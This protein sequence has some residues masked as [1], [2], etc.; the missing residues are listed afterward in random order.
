MVASRP[1]PTPRSRLTPEWPAHPVALQGP[2]LLRSASRRVYEDACP[3]A[4]SA[5]ASA[6][7]LC[8]PA[9]TLPNSTASV[10]NALAALDAA[11]R[12]APHPLSTRAN[13]A[14]LAH[15]AGTAPAIHTACALAA[16]GAPPTAIVTVSGLPRAGGADTAPLCDAL[17]LVPHL[18]V[19][20][21]SVRRSRGRAPPSLTRSPRASRAGP[22]PRGAAPPALARR[23][24]APRTRPFPLSATRWTQWR[25]REGAAVPSRPPFSPIFRGPAR[26]VC[27]ARPVPSRPAAWVTWSTQ[28][29]WPHLPRAAPPSP[30]TPAA[31]RRRWGSQLPPTAPPPSLRLMGRGASPSRAVPPPQRSA[32]RLMPV[33]TGCGPQ[34][35]PLAVA[36]PLTRSLLA[37]QPL[38]HERG[39]AH[40]DCST[41]APASFP[42]FAAAVAF[43]ARHA[44]PLERPSAPPPPPHALHACAA[45]SR[46][47]PEVP[48]TIPIFLV[49]VPLASVAALTVMCCVV[50]R[51]DRSARHPAASAYASLASACGCGDTAGKR[52]V[53]RARRNSAV[54]LPD[55]SERVTSRWLKRLASR[56]AGATAPA[57]APAPSHGPEQVAPTPGYPLSPLPPTTAPAV[58][59]PQPAPQSAATAHTVA[60]QALARH[61]EGADRASPV[62]IGES[63]SAHAASMDEPSS[64]RAAQTAGRASPAVT[65][66]GRQSPSGHSG[67]SNLSEDTRT[68]RDSTAQS[69]VSERLVDEEGYADLTSSVLLTRDEAMRGLRFVHPAAAAAAMGSTAPGTASG[70]ARVNEA[71]DGG[72]TTGGTS[73]D[74]AEDAVGLDDRWDSDDSGSSTSEEDERLGAGEEDEYDRISKGPTF[75]ESVPAPPGA[76][77]TTQVQAFSVREDAQS[78]AQSR[79]AGD[80]TSPSLSAAGV[81]STTSHPTSG[82]S[83]HSIRRRRRCAHSV[84][85]CGRRLLARLSCRRPEHGPPQ[86]EANGAEAA[87]PPAAATTAGAVPGTGFA[88][89]SGARSRRV[90]R[91]DAETGHGGSERE[92]SSVSFWGG[93][94]DAES[95]AGARPEARNRSQG[96]PERGLLPPPAV[97]L[98]QMRQWNGGGGSELVS[99]PSPA[100]GFAVRSSRSFRRV[101]SGDQAAA[102]A[103]AQ[104]GAPLSRAGSFLSGSV[105]SASSR[106]VRDMVDSLRVGAAARGG[107]PA[108]EDGAAGAGSRAAGRAPMF[109]GSERTPSD[110]ASRRTGFQSR[111]SAPTT[112]THTTHTT[113]TG[114]TNSSGSGS[115]P[116]HSSRI[117]RTPSG[118]GTTG[119]SQRSDML[120]DTAVRGSPL[121]ARAGAGAGEGGG[122]RWGSAHRQDWVDEDHEAAQEGRDQRQSSR[123]SRRRRHRGRGR[124]RR[125]PA[126]P[127]SRSPPSASPSPSGQGARRRPERLDLHNRTAAARA[128]ARHTPALVTAAA[129]AA[130]GSSQDWTSSSPVVRTRAKRREAGSA[131]PSPTSTHGSPFN[132]SPYASSVHLRRSLEQSTEEALDSEVVVDSPLLS[133]ATDTDADT[134]SQGEAAARPAPSALPIAGQAA[135]AGAAAESTIVEGDA[136]RAH[137]LSS[138]LQAGPSGTDQHSAHAASPPT[139][140]WPALLS[141]GGCEASPLRSGLEATAG[142]LGGEAAPPPRRAGASTGPRA[143]SGS[144]ASGR[145]WQSPGVAFRRTDGSSSNG[146]PVQASLASLFAEQAGSD[147][148]DTLSVI[149]PTRSAGSESNSCVT[150]G[151]GA[152]EMPS[153]PSPSPSSTQDGEHYQQRMPAE[154][155]M[156][157]A[158]P[159][160]ASRLHSDLRVTP[161]RGRVFRTSLLDSPAALSVA[162]TEDERSGGEESSPYLR[163]KTSDHTL[164]TQAPSGTWPSSQASGEGDTVTIQLPVQGG[165]RLGLEEAAARG[166]SAALVSYT[167]T[168]SPSP[169]SEATGAGTGTGTGTGT[170]G[171]SQRSRSQ[172]DR[173]H[174]TSDGGA[175]GPDGGGHRNESAPAAQTQGAGPSYTLQ[176]L[177]APSPQTAKTP[178]APT[179]GQAIPAAGAPIGGG[180]SGECS[181][182][183]AA[184]RPRLSRAPSL[185][186]RA[187]RLAGSL[188][189]M[190]SSMLRAEGGKGTH[191]AE[192]GADASTTQASVASA[193]PDAAVMQAARGLARRQ[194]QRW[195]RDQQRRERR[196]RGQLRRRASARA[197]MH[198]VADGTGHGEDE[199]EEDVHDDGGAYVVDWAG[200]AAVPVESLLSTTASIYGE[201]PDAPA[202]SATPP[203]D[204]HASH[205]LRSGQASLQ[206]ESLLMLASA[207]S[208]ADLLALDEQRERGRSIL[209]QQPRP[210]APEGEASCGLT[211]PPSGAAP[212][213]AGAGPATPTASAGPLQLP[214]PPSRRETAAGNERSPP[215]S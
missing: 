151:A 99:R 124:G 103:A 77:S 148:S 119:T 94:G 26:A 164:P 122:D 20:G 31:P 22:I 17:R 35:S 109:A 116:A 130:E 192:A 139:G 18:H 142:A 193:E 169:L 14:L 143:R 107:G 7:G 62:S 160:S 27:G 52:P 45:A 89:G 21:G 210:A 12:A 57:P 92:L 60:R 72:A 28:R 206:P 40:R 136:R 75:G 140:G 23:R 67:S 76:T 53:P 135:G 125:S 86:Y 117:S 110:T 41:A 146:R 112:T 36:P 155:V 199:E 197:A 100:D 128:R 161:Q 162:A 91:A 183:A 56:G 95:E 88:S 71:G 141:G 205:L 149:Q 211:G 173:R 84:A 82:E 144:T 78:A 2:A 201:A 131:A 59:P 43:A 105:A 29:P 98:Q 179:E 203:S 196:R 202:D 114:P 30:P 126:S 69:V 190:G 63:L 11:A 97:S 79:H 138:M 166:S 101:D 64:R 81:S 39:A 187:S 163:R 34:P 24:W 145:P 204:R 25:G 207:D 118:T 33:T 70:L 104:G 184:Q 47:R 167:A 51:K 5:F 111:S 191:S 175:T 121:A 132:A 87:L 147:V 180:A 188:R 158:G 174:D 73:T 15:G 66:D 129:P 178:G 16:S 6:D 46:P 153:Q 50:L 212:H 44:S 181:E 49:V 171:E 8:L 9:P 80:P 93:D 96:L 186:R 90:A 4:N 214:G 1:S 177:Q 134:G 156:G 32:L 83:T 208:R 120:L 54:S 209:L 13:V 102:G 154:A 133:S 115:Q 55:F 58:R 106:R 215:P 159:A 185:H 152:S 213:G 170:S 157:S 176:Q 68:T 165:A 195:L 168:T 38:S 137:P 194:S 113:Q 108:A 172:S 123:G 37:P 48:A 42:A 65:G 85:A 127:A 182:A 150:G 200:E 74:D 19:H 3:F 61:G 10:C 198:V 189:R